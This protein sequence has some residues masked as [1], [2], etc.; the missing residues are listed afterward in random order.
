MQ[1]E[2]VSFSVG[3]KESVSGALCAPE[4]HRAD[5]GI[6][7]IF[8]HGAGNDMD[9]PMIVFLSQGLAEAGFI[10]LRFN[11]PYKEKGKRAPDNQA[12]LIR[13]WQC[14]YRFLKEDSGY[15]P[16][17]I[18]A[19]GKSMGGRVA[20]QMAA[21]GLLP[22]VGLVFL[23]YPL[24]APGKKKELRDAHLYEIDIPM[25]FFAGTKDPLC[26]VDLLK[27]VLGRL[28]SSWELETIEEGDHSFNLPKS[29]NTPQHGVYDRI[30]KRTAG[31]TQALFVS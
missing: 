21:E 14:A 8:A 25:L 15:D 1:S 22:A 4:E 24:H 10:T 19:A 9:N 26:D 27:G 23:G 12:K 2:K 11:F 31:W 6:G 30:L 20:S 7:I 29:T 13:T 5:E 17:K 3:E 18:I 16:A 28:R